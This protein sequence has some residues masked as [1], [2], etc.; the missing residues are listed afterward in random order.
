MLRLFALGTLVCLTLSGCGPDKRKCT[1]PHAD[2]IVILKLANRPLPDDTVVH[3][4]YGGSGMEEYA[5]SAPGKNHEVVFCDRA[6]ANGVPLDESDAGAAGAAGATGD[7][8]DAPVQSLHCAL[9]TGGYSKVEVTATG[10]IS[11]V[12][13]LYPREQECTVEEKIDLDSPDAG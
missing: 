10:L 8:A 13:E 3:V 12:Y 7:D 1:G 6:D 11:K 2:F 4:T 9:W 5:L